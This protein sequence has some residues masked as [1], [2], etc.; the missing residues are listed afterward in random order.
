MFSL[1]ARERPE[2]KQRPQSCL[3]ANLQISTGDVMK[4]NEDLSSCI[5]NMFHLSGEAWSL[6]HRSDGLPLSYRAL[7]GAL[8][9]ATRSRTMRSISVE[10]ICGCFDSNCL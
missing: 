5:R 10:R 7:L 4:Q 1:T 8:I 2:V 3:P 6:G 9:A